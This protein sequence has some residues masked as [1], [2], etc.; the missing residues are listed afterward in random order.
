M[1][2]KDTN[3]PPQWYD[4][5][6]ESESTKRVHSPSKRRSV[7]LMFSTPDTP[8]LRSSET[9]KREKRVVFL[10]CSK[11]MKSFSK[12]PR[13][14]LE[15]DQTLFFFGGKK[16]WIFPQNEK[17]RQERDAQP[18]RDKHMSTELKNLI[19][20][21]LK[22]GTCHFL[23]KATLKYKF[24][25]GPKD[26]EAYERVSEWLV[27][28]GHNPLRLKKTYWMYRSNL[29]R[30]EAC[31][32]VRNIEGGYHEYEEVKLLLQK[33]CPGYLLPILSWRSS[34]ESRIREYLGMSP[35]D[36]DEDD[37]SEYSIGAD[38]DGV[39]LYRV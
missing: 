10:S 7:E 28:L 27:R 38:E 25:P 22:N 29:S 34:N 21:K 23:K 1:S 9:R 26:P 33:S 39:E 18:G 6:D 20:R 35:S 3:L 37:S 16:K 2:S 4:Q 8:D 19:E 11:L 13:D 24:Y 30:V 5:N 15:H 32:V 17:D 36:D 14:V 12:I 31:K